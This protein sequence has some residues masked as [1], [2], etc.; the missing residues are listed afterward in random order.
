MAKTLIERL[1]IPIT[2]WLMVGVFGFL[3]LVDNRWEAVCPELSAALLLFGMLLVAMASLG[4]LWCALFISGRKSRVLVTDGPYSACRNPLYFFSWIG[5]VGVGLATETLLI[6]GVLFLVFGAYYP[7]VIRSEEAKLRL[8]HGAAFEEYC[9]RVPRLL[10]RL[11]GWSEPPEYPVDSRRFRT[12][13]AAALWFVW[14]VGLI[15]LIEEGHELGWLPKWI[16]VY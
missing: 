9:R 12:Q 15:E 5:T 1:R 8:A 7:F 13:M 14:A 3:I 16:A 4:R 2:Q 11:T 10:P 6:P